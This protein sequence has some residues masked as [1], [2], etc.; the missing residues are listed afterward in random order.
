MPTVHVR[1]VGAEGGHIKGKSVAQNQH[2]AK[3]LANRHRMPHKE[4][5]DLIRS[6][7][8]RNVDV[9]ERPAQ[10]R[11]PHAPACKKHGVASLSQPRRHRTRRTQ[12]GNVTCCKIDR[13][14]CDYP[15]PSTTPAHAPPSRI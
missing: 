2:H 11:I 9:F 7:G 14:R 6:G 10:Q 13:H 1:A 5:L 15:H 8:G 3:C 4:R 12:H